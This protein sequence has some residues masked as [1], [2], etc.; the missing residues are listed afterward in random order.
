M[1]CTLFYD[2]PDESAIAEQIARLA[3]RALYFEVKAYPKPGLVSFID[4][5]AHHDMNGTTFYRSLFCLRHYFKQ[6]ARQAMAGSPF[7][8]L[9]QSAINA[10]Q[11]M[12]ETTQGINTHRGAIFALGLL[13]ASAARLAKS[14]Q[15][16]ESSD[17]QS[18]L[19]KDWQVALK[20]HQP[21]CRSHG[22]QVRKKYRIID[23][24]EMAV[25][26]YQ[27][28]FELL[29]PFTSVYQHSEDLNQACLFAYLKLLLTIDDSTIL[30]RKGPEAL[31]YAR[32]KA[33]ELLFIDT[34]EIRKQ[35]AI[36]LHH[37]FSE[38]GI[39]PGGV[40]DLLAVLLFLM[41]LFNSK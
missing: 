18:Q 14:Q 31:F 37:V 38:Q 3:V 4:S 13:T 40:A 2:T 23:A 17:L 6:I 27:P 7:K 12:L 20:S 11:K 19:I 33:Q 21:D 26:A 32:Q 24:R 25:I 29:L 35:R 9:R 34:L 30:Y 8:T 36:V 28:V 1:H 39:S 15:P 22:S 5:G 41:Q 10:E 16:F